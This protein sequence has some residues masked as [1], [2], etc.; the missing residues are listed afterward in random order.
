MRGMMTVDATGARAAF[1]RG[2]NS[3]SQQVREILAGGGDPLFQRKW[4]EGVVHGTITALLAESDAVQ[5][6]HLHSI[7]QRILSGRT[8]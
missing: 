4:A 1:V 8:E 3:G 2:S 5:A 7:I 6:D